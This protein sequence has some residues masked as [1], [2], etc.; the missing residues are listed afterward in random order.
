MKSAVWPTLACYFAV[1]LP[2]GHFLAFSRHKGIEGLLV[3]LLV[4][5]LLLLTVYSV[6]VDSLTNWELMWHSA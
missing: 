3:G 1:A 6:L 4:G 2:L 5:Q